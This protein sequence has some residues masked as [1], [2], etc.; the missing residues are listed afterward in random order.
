MGRGPLYSG[1][2]A[3]GSGVSS[4]LPLLLPRDILPGGLLP[5]RLLCR[6]CLRLGPVGE[7]VVELS[8]MTVLP[9]GLARSLRARGQ[10]E[11]LSPEPDLHG[12]LL[13]LD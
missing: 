11:W 6:L 5:E 2:T 10:A 13:L 9:K 8:G 12:L 4:L 1:G 3:L 7:P